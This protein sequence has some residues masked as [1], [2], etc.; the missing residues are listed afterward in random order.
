MSS[1]PE[2]A[3]ESDVILVGAD[4]LPVYCPG[5]KAPLWSMHPRIY[6]EVLKSG[7]AKCQ[8]CGAR[9]KLRDGEKIHGHH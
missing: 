4:D 1:A 3:N 7:I 5:P 6:I 2:P 9:Y 8:Y